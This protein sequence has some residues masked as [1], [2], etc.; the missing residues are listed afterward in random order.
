MR[1]RQEGS[2]EQEENPH[3][4]LNRLAPSSWASKPPK[5]WEVNFCCLSHSIWYFVVAAQAD[6]HTI[7][8]GKPIQT[9]V[10][11]LNI[12]IQ[13]NEVKLFLH[14]I[15]NSA[16]NYQR[17]TETH[18]YKILWRKTVIILNLAMISCIWHPK[19]KNK[20]QTDESNFKIKDSGWAW[21][22]CT[23]EDKIGR[24]IASSRPAW[25]VQQESV[26]NEKYLRL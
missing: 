9:L 24:G 22:H 26:T 20:E 2:Y 15:Q 21:W 19:H 18:N 4:E 12:Y 16:Q 25:T 6:Y 13:K 7:Q 8:F 3:Y 11:K 10:E 17:P 1:T 5:Q 23:L 14:H